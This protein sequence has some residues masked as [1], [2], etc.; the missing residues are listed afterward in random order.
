MRIVALVKSTDHVCCRYRVAPFRTHFETLGHQFDICP[1]SASWLARQMVAS[2]RSRVDALIVQRKLFPWWK[3][4]LVRR[5]ARRL[6]FDF[7]DSIY[8]RSSHD[9]R[10]QDCRTRLV[11]FRNTL[12]SADAIVTGNEF[13]HDLASTITDNAKIHRIPTCV[14][15]ARYPLANHDPDKK[16]IKLAW[17]GSS[18][19]MRGLENV[20]EALERLA[21]HAPTL[22]LKVI[23][24]RS[25]P[26]KRLH[27]EFM[28]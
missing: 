13:L 10:G 12:R 17:I 28:R 8:M 16:V 25:I 24:D 15:A 11:R 9:P 19:T 26:L 21:D 3:L 5:Q 14:D 4:Q 1:W 6:I 7:D 23:C 22:Q 18:S 2:F 27:V 20:G